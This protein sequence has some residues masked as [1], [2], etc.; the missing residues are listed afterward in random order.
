MSTST[1]PNDLLLVSGKALTILMQ[2]FMSI[3]AFALLITIPVLL[4]Y[5]ADIAAELTAELGQEI[6]DFPLPTIIALLVMA[7]MVVALV[8][9]FFDQLR[10]II[11]TVGH[12]DPF[13]PQNARRLGNM[14]WLLLVVQLLMIP[15]SGAGLTVAKWADEVGHEDITVDAGLDLTG[16]LMVIVL[17]ILARVFKR[18]AEMRDDLEGTV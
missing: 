15:I 1:R 4:F 7:L 2:I 8:F 10:R 12:G 9:A 14:G 11:N 16:I 6:T 13:A 3:A 5:Q 17:F 18:G